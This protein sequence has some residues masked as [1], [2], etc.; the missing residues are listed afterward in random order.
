[1][2]RL[3]ALL[4]CLLLLPA[5]F[6]RGDGF[7]VVDDP[8]VR[9]G[10]GHFPFAPL[11]VVRHRVTVEIDNGVA[12]TKVDQT[13]HN[14]SGRRTE[15][16]YLFPLPEGASIDKFSMDVDGTMTDAELL[17]ADK[18]RRIYEEIVRTQRDPALLEYAGR[19]AFKARVFPIEPNGD[20]RIRLQ[21]TQVLTPDS[22][23]TEYRYSLNTEKFSAAP[24]KEVSVTVHLKS[25]RP[26]KS[27]Y[28]PSHN[29]EVKRDGA[30]AAT[31]TY[32]ETD[33]RPDA[34]FKLIYSADPDPVGITLLTHRAD[35]AE[36]GYFLLMASP[37]EASDREV[38]VQ[39]K[40]V[41]FVLDTSG[42]MA[43]PKLDQARRAL[44][45]C[46]A[47][48][49]EGDR[50]NVVRFSTEAEVL[51]DA[52]AP[53]DKSHVAE[54]RAFVDKLK[55][56]GGTA[57]GAAL[58]RANELQKGASGQSRPFVTIFLTDGQP[59]IGET[60]EDKLVAASGGSGR[61]FPFGIGADVNT[62]LLDRIANGTRAFSQYV[63]PTEDIE[64]KVSDFYAKIQ[65]PVMTGVKLSILNATQAFTPDSIRATKI[66]PAD[67]PD[68]YRGQTLLAFGRYSGS[69]FGTV[70]VRGTI[71][72]VER[73][74][75]RDLNFPAREA[76][77]DYIPKLWATRRVGWLLDEIRLRGESDELKGEVTRL[78]RAHGIV[79]PYTAYLIIEDESRRN[80]PVASQTLRGISED[81]EVRRRAGA[82]YDS[83]AANSPALVKSGPQALATAK[84][85][86]G[87]KQSTNAQQAQ[88]ASGQ[89]LFANQDAPATRPGEAVGYR[90]SQA[91][92]YARQA[93]AV[94]GRAFYLNAGVWVDSRLQVADARK[95]PRRAVAFNSDAY[96]ALL[97]AYPDVAKWLALGPQVDVIVGGTVYNVR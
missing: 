1:M 21:Y 54:A 47:N 30:S 37:G 18:A 17:P 24:L 85:V 28:C 91:Q 46:L 53:A 87:L 40:D 6:A 49:N 23:A 75:S 5:G 2:P 14:P 43:G 36:D 67:L 57:I 13:F 59:T 20:K 42:S 3:T 58:A 78:A 74:F 41:C 34:D 73:T 81:R 11:E 10:P 77:N 25:D 44:G 94:N 27:V 89:G 16:T 4:L 70:S 76:A 72:G 60:D 22:G 12:V 50:F 55:P 68:L 51:F 26:L 92:N 56:I 97:D 48:L 45:F 38:K 88:G 83:A 86:G 19:G 90:Q 32:E 9:G 62:H 82:V 96:Y 69:G 71:G 84:D 63:L 39:P 93:A 15:G 61:I 8:A 7:I 64:V 29:V 66:L 95:L 31:V 35:P 79:T 80:V 65:S 52:M 33:A